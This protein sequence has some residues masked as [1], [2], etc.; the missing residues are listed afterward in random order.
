VLRKTT[1]DTRYFVPQSE[2]ERIIIN[3]VDSDNDMWNTMV[4]VTCPWE[5]ELEGERGA[6]PTT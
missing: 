4:R 3:M 6:I 2:C 1:Q 5:V